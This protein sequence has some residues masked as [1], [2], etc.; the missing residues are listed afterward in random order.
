MSDNSLHDLLNS[1]EADRLGKYLQAQR[2]MVM[3]N[4]AAHSSS[5][6]T[7]LARE[8]N[9]ALKNSASA[10]PELLLSSQVE[11]ESTKT[12]NQVEISK[13][14][15]V[16]T[17]RDWAEDYPEMYYFVGQAYYQMKKYDL[18]ESAFRRVTENPEDL[19]YYYKCQQKEAGDI[20]VFPGNTYM[21]LNRTSDAMPCFRTALEKG[22]PDELAEEIQAFLKKHE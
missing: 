9:D 17:L 10:Y 3:M 5:L 18:A 20:F 6:L 21:H 8:V 7:S 22:L 16:K 4:A 19:S 11:K 1:P 13:R 12:A 15:M 2:M 14:N